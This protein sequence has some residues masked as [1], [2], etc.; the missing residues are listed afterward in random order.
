MGQEE[1]WWLT[2]C[3]LLSFLDSSQ[4]FQSRSCPVFSKGWR[5]K[6]VA[7]CT[8]YGFTDGIYP[9]WLVWSCKVTALTPGHSKGCFWKVLTLW[10]CSSLSALLGGSPTLFRWLC[11]SWSTLLI[12]GT[13]GKFN[14]PS[15]STLGWVCS[16][17]GL[18]TQPALLGCGPWAGCARTPNH[19]HSTQS[20]Q[21]TQGG[22]AGQAVPSLL[23]WC[24]LLPGLGTALLT[25]PLTLGRNADPLYQ[26]EEGWPRGRSTN[27]KYRASNFHSALRKGFFYFPSFKYVYVQNIMAFYFL[28]CCF[29]SMPSSSHLFPCLCLSCAGLPTCPCSAPAVPLFC[30]A[31]G[32][33]GC[34]TPLQPRVENF[35]EI[36]FHWIKTIQKN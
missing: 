33:H 27:L 26:G 24:D 8:G 18:R 19:I 16:V 15:K 31:P 22:M 23:G 9:I 28:V 34:K 32:G 5:P 2:F 12:S 35:W 10:R 25:F 7:V 4:L 20:L 13:A 36:W 1:C 11:T 3:W 21:G 14:K 17:T 29:P 30:P 6:R